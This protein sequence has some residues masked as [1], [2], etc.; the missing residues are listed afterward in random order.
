MADKTTYNGYYPI[1]A[2]LITIGIVIAAV[3][4]KWGYY[5]VFMFVIVS[6]ILVL[7]V[8]APALATIM[9]LGGGGQ[10]RTPAGSVAQQQ[11][12]TA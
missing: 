1:V 10:A 8:G 5:L 4:T 7:A 12:V 2:W 6:I 11:L 9:Q 3:R